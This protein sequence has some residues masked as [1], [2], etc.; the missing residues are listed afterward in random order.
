MIGAA[1]GSWTMYDRTDSGS[2]LRGPGF[3]LASTLI[4]FE[5][6]TGPFAIILPQ[7]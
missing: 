7:P 6:P 5:A 1:V 2:V 4:E 3:F